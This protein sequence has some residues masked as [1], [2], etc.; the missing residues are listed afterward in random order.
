MNAKSLKTKLIIASAVLS[1]AALVSFLKD[2]GDELDWYD[3][4]ILD[5]AADIEALRAQI[6]E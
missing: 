6:S 5:N 2:I 1:T 3:S 4:R